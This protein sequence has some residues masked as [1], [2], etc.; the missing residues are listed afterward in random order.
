MEYIL[1]GLK[2]FSLGHHYIQVVYTPPTI[3]RS[4]N[5]TIN[6]QVVSR[7]SIFWANILQYFFLVRSFHGHGHGKNAMINHDWCIFLFQH[8]TTS[9]SHKLPFL[10]VEFNLEKLN[11][12]LD[13]WVWNQI[14]YYYDVVYIDHD[15]FVIMGM[16]QHHQ[17][18]IC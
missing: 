16:L 11:N 1:K 4:R 3:S 15:S 14:R 2:C 10:L 8:N 18:K 6:S 13:T 5:H 12:L 9:S 17:W 7:I